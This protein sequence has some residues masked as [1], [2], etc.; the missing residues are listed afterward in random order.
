MCLGAAYNTLSER[1]ETTF[2][3][4]TIVLLFYSHG[5]ILLKSTRNYLERPSSSLLATGKSKMAEIVFL[6]S[7]FALVIA[8]TLL[9]C[10]RVGGLVPKLQSRTK[11]SNN[12]SEIRAL[13]EAKELPDWGTNQLEGLEV[14]SF[15]N[16]HL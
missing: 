4:I 1:I 6:V 15:S 13:I 16:E 7:C 11:R 8:T 14:R 5:R 9:S 3:N 12:P 10:S 2:K